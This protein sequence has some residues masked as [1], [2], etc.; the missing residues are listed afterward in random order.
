MNEFFQK[1]SLDEI[2]DA[3]LGGLE[4]AGRES[5]GNVE[6]VEERDINKYHD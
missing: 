4:E 3:Q 6:Q 2:K 1:E 5:D